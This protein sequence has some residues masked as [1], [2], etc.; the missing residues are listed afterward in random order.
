[1][2]DSPAPP[3]PSLEGHVAALRDTFAGCRTRKQALRIADEL[4]DRQLIALRKQSVPPLDPDRV[5]LDGDLDGMLAFAFLPG[6]VKGGRAIV[7]AIIDNA[8]APHHEHGEGGEI[9]YTLAGTLRDETDDGQR[10]L[11]RAG[12]PPLVHAGKTRHQPGSRS[13]WV[14]VYEQPTGA[15]NL[16]EPTGSSRVGSIHTA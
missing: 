5:K 9:I 4:T 12:D 3:E 16:P 1:M 8:Y 14:G 15:M 11:H 7:L 6:S 10:V 13:C 2:T